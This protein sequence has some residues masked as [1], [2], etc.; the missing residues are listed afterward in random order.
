MRKQFMITTDWITTD[1]GAADDST[2]GAWVRL[3]AYCAPRLNGGRIVGAKG[4]TRDTAPRV[5]GVARR[6]FDAM[7]A[8]G[9]AQWDGN[10]L[11]LLGYDGAGERMWQ[12][13]SHGGAVGRQKQIKARRDAL[14][15]PTDSPVDNAPGTPRGVP[16]AEPQGIARGDSESE[17]ESEN[18]TAAA[19]AVPDR[20]PDPRLAAV[21]AEGGYLDFKD[22]DLRPQWIAD[23]G[24]DPI[25]KIREVMRW[26]R[27][28]SN[29]PV[30][31]PSAYCTHRKALAERKRQEIERQRQRV[32]QETQRTQER[33]E[34]DER[35]KRA[36]EYQ[37][38]QRAEIAALLALA[39]EWTDR[40]TDEQAA[41][42]GELRITFDARKSFG[43][44]LGRKLD[45]LPSALVEQA[46]ARANEH[47]EE[48]ITA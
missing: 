19:A 1:A 15:I 16:G 8:A 18:D 25:E 26:G 20:T 21:A 10:D 14:G 9:I 30:R 28:R 5:C 23:L 41:I 37:A 7:V 44:T 27:Q 12:A 22:Q 43:L 3:H 13:K 36:A 45:K 2:L 40:L 42:I 33:A 11:V 31:M 6:S 17:G 32:E 38:R 39:D 47:T 46:K 24:E 35:A 34:Q 4:W 29:A 48:G